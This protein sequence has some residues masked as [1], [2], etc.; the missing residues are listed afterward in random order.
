RGPAWRHHHVRRRH[1]GI[2]GRRRR[3]A[4]ARGRARGRPG[5]R[6]GRGDAGGVAR[7]AGGHQRPV[8]PGGWRPGD[9]S[10]RRRTWSLAPVRI[11][12]VFIRRPVLATML[13]AAAAVLGLFSYRSLGVDLFPNVD[14]PIVTVTTTLKGAGV[15]EMETGV[16]KV[17]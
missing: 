11:A 1:Q 13:V 17:L 5:R 2:R 6:V 14:F 8:A 10:R 15:E 9:D 3:R 4:R 7:D 16:T 12:D